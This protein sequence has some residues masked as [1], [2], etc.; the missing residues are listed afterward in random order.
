MNPIISIIMGST[1][2]WKVMEKAATL[3]NDLEIP[4]EINALSA[5]RTP[6]KVEEISKNAEAR[7]IKII[8]VINKI[9]FQ[10]ILYYYIICLSVY[11]P[12]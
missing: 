1:S 5:H 7:G 4:F 12:K 10:N 2:D 9:N 3:L 11:S 8:I 6:E